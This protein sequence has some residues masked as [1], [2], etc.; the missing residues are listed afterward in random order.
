MSPPPEVVDLQ[1][2]IATVG[3]LDTAG[4]TDAELAAAVR[5]LEEAR[6]QRR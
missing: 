2:A 3:A 6:D 5:A 1:R 4:L